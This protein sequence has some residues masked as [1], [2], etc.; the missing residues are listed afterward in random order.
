[1]SNTNK[2]VISQLGQ[3]E[4][5]QLARQVAELKEQLER[6]QHEIDYLASFPELHPHP[7]VEIDRTGQITYHNSAAARLFPECLLPGP[8][9]TLLADLPEII[10]ELTREP[11]PEHQSETRTRTREV[12][13][14]ERWYQQVMY[15]VPNTSRIRCLTQDT[16]E[17]KQAEETL[18]RQNGYLAALHEVTLGVMSRLDVDDVLEAIVSRAAQL[19][20][21][22][23]GVVFLQTERARE[24]EQKVGIG[25]FATVVGGRLNAGEGVCGQ[26]WQTGEPVVVTDYAR[27][28]N[29]ASKFD[30]HLISAMAAVP[31]HSQER[32]IG[33]LGMAYGAGSHRTFGDAEV[34]LLARFAELASLALDNARLFAES[35]EYTHK[36][37]MLNEMGR[38]MS[39][40]ETQDQVF[41]IATEYAPD[42]VKGGHSAVSLLEETGDRLQ[43][44][45]LKCSLNLTPV[46][47]RWPLEGTIVGQAV[48]EKR[49][50]N[51]PD[52]TLVDA[53]D[54]HV[55]AEP[56]VRSAITAPL[57]YGDRVIG[58]LRV[59][60][61][62]PS[63][64]TPRDESLVRQVASF[65]ATSIEN[66]RLYNEAKEARAV[67][68]AANQAKSAFLA[69][70]SHEIRT[71]MNGIIGMTSL[72]SDTE[73]DE[74]QREFVET[75]REGGDALLTIINDIL[76]F[77][78]IEA[79]RLELENQPFDVRECVESSLDLLAARAAEKGLDL[80]YTI[81]PNTPEA[82][83]GDVT[84]LRQVLVNLLSNA[85]KF[86]EKGEVVVTLT[87]EWDCRPA[88]DVGGNPC[89]LRFTVRD[90]GI[91]IPPDR[92]DRL[93]QSFSQ[94]DASMTRRYGGTGLG[95]AISKR[96][97]ELMGGTM[98]VESELGIGS[99]FHFTLNG[100]TAPTPVRAYQ[101]DV[102]P[103]LAGKRALIVDDN[104]TNR[105][106]VSLQLEGWQMLTQD[107]ESPFEALEWLRD[108]AHAAP[109]F[110]VVVLDM[111]M[112]GLDGLTLAR[113]IRKLPAPAGELPLIM[114]TSLGHQGAREE[115]THFAAFITKP[116]KPSA[117]FDALV[118][119]FAGRPMRV[120]PRK[121]GAESAFD[122]EMGVKRPL[123]ILLA[124]DNA[125][126][127]KLALQLLARMAY[128][129]DVASNGREALE[130]LARQPYDLVLMDV[131]M[132]EI[133]G[134]EATRHLRNELPKARQPYVIA[135]TANAMQGDRDMCLAAGMDDYVSK[136]I[137]VEELVAA[138]GRIAGRGPRPEAGQPA[139]ST[140]SA[141]VV[142]E[143]ESVTGHQSNAE[144]WE[145]VLDPKALHDLLESLGGE[146]DLLVELFD[147][148]LE[149]APKLL[150]ELGDSVESGN[151]TN[152]H[153]IAHSLK[154][155]GLDL[156]AAAFARD[157]KGLELL[158]K[159]GSLDGASALYARI[160][161]EYA[162]VATALRNL[163]TARDMDFAREKA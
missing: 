97:C 11:G 47:S 43:V 94:V 36:L 104:A 154:S 90:T 70:M 96:L 157:C 109:A 2:N 15:L 39:L 34:E 79:D 59:A 158:A 101:D 131:Q 22:E 148:F 155:N 116:V 65:L 136:P 38:L 9:S 93:F 57:L 52:L 123:R 161:A 62:E 33:V 67:A 28:E 30:A 3:D 146:F 50:I 110:D 35:E 134:L 24:I 64:F 27:Y 163:R 71:P 156:G 73:L 68:V 121:A 78:K 61:I 83:F 45:A 6:A 72:L 120:V 88:D 130:A 74:Q 58:T 102:Q 63:A 12:K 135:M 13:L 147:A 106:V 99:S 103:L 98:W 153:R 127:Q 16:T 95:L 111:Q 122:P 25:A 66:V 140:S 8:R 37:V 129:A 7:V 108:G 44:L 46:G 49:L 31:L 81:D 10:D 143:K 142:A 89:L 21:A 105:R 118:G 100:T 40:A 4:P 152:V 32:A 23:H 82:I 132:P 87:S 42:L 26:V 107:A 86:T 124:E 56:G 151:V 48:R 149:D 75:I 128:R 92:L 41:E 19:L 5:A 137:R 54:A 85:V 112:P 145:T 1:M 138:L 119:T 80:V 117:L 53:L 77:S 20:G 125:T 84:R 91:G 60:S 29:R 139:A 162:D 51:T 160:A 144:T 17:R 114:L 14:G 141:G 113:E 55:L 126:N 76:D 159:S 69:N 133:D 18:L 150:A 115:S